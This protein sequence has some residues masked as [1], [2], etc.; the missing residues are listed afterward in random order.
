MTSKEALQPATE[1]KSPIFVEFEKLFEQ[2][3]DFTETVAK[4]A[5]EFFEA[6]GYE[7]GHELEDWFRAESE[8]MR[9]V[10][11]EM[12][13][14]E[15]TLTIRAEVP[16]FEAKDIKVSV[17]QRQ[18]ILTGKTE[19]ATEEKKDETIYNERRMNQFY[20]SFTLPTE[21]DATNVTASVKNGVLELTLPKVAKT[22]AV[23]VEVK[24]A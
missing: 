18:L 19:M 10:P 7:L 3:K 4:R 21:V 23:Q 9:R 20:R 13:E 14:T 1:N 24:T 6:R 22:E 17:E 8:L 16:G 2:M 12:T 15:T 5:Y 11:V